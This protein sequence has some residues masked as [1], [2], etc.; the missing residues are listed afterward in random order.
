MLQLVYASAAT[1]Q[2]SPDDLLGILRVSRRNNTAVGV[3]GA[4]LYS[5]GNFMQVLEGPEGRVIGTFQRIQKDPRHRGLLVMLR[6]TIEERQFPEWSMGF[7]TLDGL[8][9]ED[10]AGAQ[11]LFDLTADGPARV[12]RLLHTFRRL[13]ADMRFETRR[14]SG[15]DQ[16]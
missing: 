3:T 1:P 11:T 9:D 12:Q 8:D 6:Q 10:R 15:R 13:P 14:D 5:G 16:A 7:R 2:F 4:L